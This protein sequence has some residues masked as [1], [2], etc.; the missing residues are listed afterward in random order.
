MVL[1]AG[2]LDESAYS[3]LKEILAMMHDVESAIV[4]GRPANVSQADLARA[5]DVV[6]E[7]LDSVGEGKIEAAQAMKLA[8]SPGG[9]SSA[10]LESSRGAGD[11]AG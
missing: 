10:S 3:A 4:A 6:R 7:V 9:L 11:S 1:K 5:A 8:A 2:S